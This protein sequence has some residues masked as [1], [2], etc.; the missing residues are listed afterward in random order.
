MK[1]VL[2][3]GGSGFIGTNV[4][5]HWMDKGVEAVNFDIRP[6]QNPAHA[7]RWQKVDLLDADALAGAMRDLRP[8]CVIHLAA[9]ADIEGTHLDD[10]R[11]NTEG[12]ENLVAAV[13]QSG[14]PRVLFTSSQL[15]CRPGYRPTT[16]TDYCPPNPY[17]VSKVR[18][19]EI[20]RAEGRDDF[21]WTLMRPTSIWGPW[22]EQPYRAFFL[23]VRRGRYLQARGLRVPKSFGFVGNTV[24][25]M[26]RLALCPAERIHGRVLY[27]ADYEAVVVSEWAETVRRAWGA[28]PIREVPLGLLRAAALAGDQ[29]KR[30]GMKNPPL[31]SYRLR[32]LLTESAQDMGPLREV[33]GPMPYSVAEGT[34]ITVAW[35]RAQE[36]GATPGPTPGAR[37][38]E[39]EARGEETR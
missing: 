28:P 3:T 6:P 15:V 1:R 8:D 37:R 27:V 19:E 38:S 21:V 35:M 18:T 33:C 32:N 7:D 9:R 31:T 12:V 5:Q 16:D 25:Q 17:G 11:I 10:Y 26:E 34:D 14:A 4:M 39:E 13:K 36:A 2:V 20:A 23:T 29:L 24:V 30:L 22:F